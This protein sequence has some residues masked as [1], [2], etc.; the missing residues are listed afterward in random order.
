MALLI[1]SYTED[2]LYPAYQDRLLMKSLGVQAGVVGAEDYKIEKVAGASLQVTAKA[3]NAFVEQTKAI[4]ESENTFY[5]GLYQVPNPKL[6]EPSNTVTVPEVNP[7]IAQII[8]RVYDEP[9]LKGAGESKA[10]LEWLN[11]AESVG[12]TEAK[13]KE[14]IYNGVAALPQSSLRLAYVLVPKKATKAEEYYIEDT[15]KV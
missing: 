9:E 14:G 8:L 4:E 11:G 3:G 10:K 12:A 2:L 5:N 6:L 7:Q 1:P 13:I 15:R